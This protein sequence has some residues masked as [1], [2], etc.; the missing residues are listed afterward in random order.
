MRKVLLATCL[1]SAAALAVGS[2]S[3]NDELIKMSQN[4]KD[5]VMPA[6]DY[7]N[8]RYSK[9]NQ[10]NAQNVGK[11]QVAWTFSTGVLRGHE[12]GPL[13]IGNMMYVHTPFPNK[14]YAIDLSQENKIVWKYEPK[15]DPNVIPV[16]CC[17]TVNR[18]LSYGDGKI[19]LHQADTN[20]VALDAKTGQVAWSATNGNP[21]KGETG[22]SS[23]LVVKD[24]VLVGIS[25]GEFG[26]QCHVTAYDLKSGKQVWRAYSTG[27][28]DQIKVDP[29]KTTSLGK[30]VGPDSSLKSWQGDQW[31]IGGGCTWGWIS[32][33]PALN[34]VYYGSGNPSTWNPKQRPGD[35]KWSMAIFARDADTGMA[36][37]VYQMTPHDEWDYDGV[38]EMILSDQ[39]INGQN[40][41]LLTH[42]DR[43]GLAYTMDRESGELLVAEKYDPKVNWT[44]GV[45]MDKN[46]PT[47]GRPKVVAQYSTEHGGE[48]KNTKG[49]CPA[50]L[51]TK[52]QQP[53]AYSPDTQLFYVPTN[54]VC[55]DY[56][57]FKVS[58]T[59]GQPYVG[60]T[61]SMYPP[62]GESHMGNFIAWDNKTGKIVWS[63]KEQFSVW[64][65][66]LA[67]AGGVVFYGTLEGYLKAVDAKTGKELYKF[68]TPSGII[69]NVTTYENNGKQY[70]AILSGVGGWA[71]IGLAAGLTDP[72]A[73]LGAVGGYA[74]L[75]NYTAL[76]GTLTVFSLPN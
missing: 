34:L 62:Q 72:T 11:L 64:S 40:R 10:I 55:M 65:G 30:P 6:G 35:N 3:A 8:T 44:S 20:L 73:G 57:P 63:N 66:A 68:K 1:G 45:D 32:Y 58:Y 41:K 31:K 43:N 52:D 50:A 19:I 75:S 24:K 9:L 25:G 13:I 37:W 56:E 39:Q 36:K 49:I 7:A 15:Q 51:G 28:D 14:V 17:D 61:L 4:P 12:G 59:A 42:F 38:N 29:A 18:G 67:T 2:A 33:D 48:D 69:G 47:Y 27:P 22:T 60:A 71:G 16:M 54:H 5:W 21:A 26:V 74:A 53:A 70:I 46:S 23:A 76:G